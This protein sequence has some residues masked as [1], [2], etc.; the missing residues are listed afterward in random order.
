MKHF[1]SYLR[2][3]LFLLLTVSSVRAGYAVS[4]VSINHD[5]KTVEAMIAALYTENET[6]KASNEALNE[7]LANY[8]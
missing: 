8:I 3:I 6:E 1:K 4:W 5:K 7:I 2:F